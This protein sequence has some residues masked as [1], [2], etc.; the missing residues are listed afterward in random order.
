MI[1][2]R[3]A[4]ERRVRRATPGQSPSIEGHLGTGRVR[5][6]PAHL[7]AGGPRAAGEV[8]ARSAGAEPL[9]TETAFDRLLADTRT[10]DSVQRRQA[11][12]GELLFVQGDEAAGLWLLQRGRIRV[13]ASDAD[14]HEQTLQIIG[15]GGTFNEVPFFDRGP[16]PATAF[17]LEAS[18]LLVLPQSRRDA[19]LRLA[20][21]L[22]MLAA[23]QFAA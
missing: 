20:P 7:S 3:P 17:A 6:S 22:A 21:E 23:E 14:G 13:Y 11:N 2:R 10:A 12:R 15:P 18:Q 4:P 19:V 8:G 5:P 9:R 1:D 16:Q